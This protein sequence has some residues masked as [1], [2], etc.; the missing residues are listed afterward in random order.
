MQHQ[1]GL[2]SISYLQLLAAQQLAQQTRINLVTAQ[3]R[4]LIDTSA[5]YQAMGA[6]A[7]RGEEPIDAP[8][9]VED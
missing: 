3:A 9:L 1:Y 7:F 8:A 5:L 6:G 2:G 4:R